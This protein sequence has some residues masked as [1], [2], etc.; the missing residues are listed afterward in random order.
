METLGNDSGFKTYSSFIQF[1][2]QRKGV[3]PSDFNKNYNS[4]TLE[5]E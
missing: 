5:E 3:L 2:K 1:F 4:N